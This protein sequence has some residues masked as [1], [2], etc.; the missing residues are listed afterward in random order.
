[1]HEKKAKK[2]LRKSLNAKVLQSDFNSTSCVMLERQLMSYWQL[3]HRSCSV[4]A[5]PVFVLLLA[6]NWRP[7]WSLMYLVTQ[8][9][10][11]NCRINAQGAHFKFRIRRGTLIPGWRY[12]HLFQ[13]LAETR[14]FIWWK[15]LFEDLWNFFPCTV[16]SSLSSAILTFWLAPAIYRVLFN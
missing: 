8:L 13:N 11:L 14:A 6:E 9:V 15:P 3:L 4:I 1:M 5:V 10:N 2:T 12:W 7:R 16:A